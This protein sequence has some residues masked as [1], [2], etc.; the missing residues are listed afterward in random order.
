MHRSV[1]SAVFWRDFRGYFT[2]P[3]GYV[4]I[5]LFIVASASLLFVWGGRFFNENLANLNILN[6]YMPYLL[7]LFV[8]AVTMN[9]WAEERR[10]GTDAL[11]LTLP[12]TD[13]DVVLG[14]YLAVVAI[15]TVA[16]LF[17]LSNVIFLSQ[18]GDPD[19]GL[20]LAT[21]LGY[22]LMGVAML[23]AGMVGSLLSRNATIGFV[24]GISLCALTVA[25]EMLGW[26]STSAKKLVYID[27]VAADGTESQS[28]DVAPILFLLAFV[29][30]TSSLRSVTR[31]WL[32]PALGMLTALFVAA[33]V[34]LP[35]AWWNEAQE[36]GVI[37]RFARLGDGEAVLGDLLYFVAIAAAFLFLNVI[38]L[39]RRFWA[40]NKDS[41]FRW[42]H[43]V[44]RC[45]AVFV[46]AISF[47]L[48]LGYTDL[49]ADVTAERLH[50]VSPVTVETLRAIAG[51]DASPVLIQ[52]YVSP[53]VPRDLV[54]SRLDLLSLLR[55]IEDMGRG[56]VRV[57]VHETREHT[58][59]AREAKD[60]FGIEPANVS[61]VVAGR[62]SV[63]AVYMGVAMSCGLERAV[64]PYL[65]KG[66]SAEYELVRSLKTVTGA[67]RRRVGILDT[68]LRIFGGYDSQSEQ[69]LPDAPIVSELKLQYD[70]IKV[71]PD[72]DY[73]GVNSPV[74]AES[75]VGRL[76]ALIAILPT[77]LT[78]PQMDKLQAFAEAGNPVLLVIDPMPALAP[79]FSAEWVS[80]SRRP[81]QMG[82]P[83]QDDGPPKGNATGLFN[84]LGFNMKLTQL[85]WSK[86]NPHPALANLSA[87]PEA[88]TFVHEGGD[89]R[90]KCFSDDA[91]ET[92][93]LQEVIMMYP[94]AVTEFL[95]ASGERKFTPLLTAPLNS[96][97]VGDLVLPS[98]VS[99]MRSGFGLHM[100]NLPAEYY[101]APNPDKQP[102]LAASIKGTYG[103]KNPSRVT[104][105]ADS[106]FILHPQIWQLR[107]AG[108]DDLNFDNVT[109]LLNCID[110]LAGDVSL[111]DLRKRRPLHRTLSVIEAERDALRDSLDETQRKAEDEAKAEIERLEA[112]NQAKLAEIDKMEGLDEKSKQQLRS[113]TSQ[114]LSAVLNSRIKDINEAKDQRIALAKEKNSE[115]VSGIED[116]YKVWAIVIPPIPALLI[117]LAVAMVRRRREYASLS[118]KRML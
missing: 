81:D 116:G 97:F 73:A 117:G 87:K 103:N 102:I 16:L 100:L 7:L 20:M 52:A 3:A 118:E 66:L 85:V 4:F 34:L 44:L 41:R 75:S 30:I 19:G 42:V 67:A 45:V 10:Q 63:Q 47:V 58:A 106:D 26:L 78:Q 92:S 77:L 1:I 84:A 89:R 6:Q 32:I 12:A 54:R 36:F 83:P 29:A 64:I 71:S 76:H 57:T 98:L 40:G 91:P 59:R 114:S 43:A 62:Q 96:G 72:T 82:R 61:D 2:T 88:F 108:V 49:R 90:W 94:G 112:Q 51:S 110:E 39:G 37:R 21:Y 50:S 101:E 111:I 14:K 11:L 56:R 38:L 23:P 95:G 105:F 68:G 86:H 18:L 79:Q 60:V 15:F 65:S 33:L 80:Q 5:S 93:G 55:R 13:S 28:F 8:P 99:R 69:D 31:S 17:S 74:E 48:L 113:A 104:V 27:T 25:P 115:V 109:L 24:L 46:A 53:E 35:A 70:V 22:W 107:A 9:V